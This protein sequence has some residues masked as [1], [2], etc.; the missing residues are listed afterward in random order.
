MT[1]TGRIREHETGFEWQTGGAGVPLLVS[2]VCEVHGIKVSE[3]GCQVVNLRL[4]D[5][6]RR[7]ERIGNEKV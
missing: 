3:A 7:I 6:Q 5:V 1:V 2:R 4:A